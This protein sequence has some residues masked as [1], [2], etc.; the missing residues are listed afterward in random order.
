M[1]LSAHHNDICQFLTSS[2]Q[3]YFTVSNA[4]DEL[5]GSG[6]RS[7]EEPK[8]MSIHVLTNSCQPKAIAF[9]DG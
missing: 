3:N 1:P 6:L 8:R 4:I 5:V 9:A 2:S 7:K